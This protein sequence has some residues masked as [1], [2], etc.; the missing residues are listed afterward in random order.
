MTQ[1]NGLVAS[2]KAL[3]STLLC[4]AQTRLELLANEMEEDR[5]RM[6]RLVLFSLFMFLFF[7]LGIVM[8]TLMIIVIYWDTYRL[9][10][11]GLVALVYLVVAAG[12]AVYL[13][14]EIRL[15]PKIFSASIAELIKDRVALEP[16]E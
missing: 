5:L 16:G 1:S 13:A 11:I 10:A 3:M 8:F 12:L 15:K 2:V 14:R 7:C 9:L 4:I 6:I